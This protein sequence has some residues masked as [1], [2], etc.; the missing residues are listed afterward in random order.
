MIGLGRNWFLKSR[1]ARTGEG[2]FYAI[3]YPHRQVAVMFY[4]SMNYE[5]AYKGALHIYN[6]ILGMKLPQRKKG[7]IVKGPEERGPI[8]LKGKR[9]KKGLEFE[10]DTSRYLDIVALGILPET[11]KV[12]FSVMGKLFD[13]V[14]KG[15]EELRWRARGKVVEKVKFDDALKEYNRISYKR[16]DYKPKSKRP[17]PSDIVPERKSGRLDKVKKKRAE[18]VRN[19]ARRY[20]IK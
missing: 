16:P 13:T 14:L 11:R 9:T 3:V 15:D 6:N 18:K 1:S 7:L 2:K 20:M 10:F 8:M 17:K 4:D 19:R 5:G 12:V